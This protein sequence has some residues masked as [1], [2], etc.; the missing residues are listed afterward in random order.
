V[1]LADDTIR[2]T[3]GVEGRRRQ[4]GVPKDVAVGGIERMVEA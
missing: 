4:V 2:K 1:V 3:D